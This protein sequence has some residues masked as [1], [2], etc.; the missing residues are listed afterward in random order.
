MAVGGCIF[1]VAPMAFLGIA[2]VRM[3]L[4]VFLIAGGSLAL[5]GIKRYRDA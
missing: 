4:P 1:L 2:E 3:W 5:L